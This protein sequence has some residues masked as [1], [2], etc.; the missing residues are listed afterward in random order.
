MLGYGG[1]LAVA[2]LRSPPLTTLLRLY[3]LDFPKAAK[4]CPPNYQS[5]FLVFCLA[6]FGISVCVSEAPVQLSLTASVRHL[7]PAL[8]HSSDCNQTVIRV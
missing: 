7:L 8:P 3:L 1:I 6:L 2:N 5:A 4:H